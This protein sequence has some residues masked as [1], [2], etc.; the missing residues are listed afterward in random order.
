[1]MNLILSPQEPGSHYM[2]KSETERRVPTNRAA[3]VLKIRAVVVFSKQAAK[4]VKPDIS[5]P[6]TLV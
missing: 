2:V 5:P 1:M 3:T 4:Q 6:S